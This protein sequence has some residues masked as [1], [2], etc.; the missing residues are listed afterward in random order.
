MYKSILRV[1]TLTIENISSTVL[2]KYDCMNHP[3]SK[4]RKYL[5]EH[6][7]EQSSPFPLG[8]YFILRTIF[9][10]CRVW[11]FINVFKVSEINSFKI[12]MMTAH[13]WNPQLKRL[14]ASGF[15][16]NIK[17]KAI[18]IVWERNLEY[19]NLTLNDNF[20]CG[21]N[22]ERIH[23]QNLCKVNYSM[24]AT[25]ASPLFPNPFASDRLET[26]KFRFT[27]IISEFGYDFNEKPMML[28]GI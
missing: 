4:N 13:H 8:P 22:G 16:Q 11:K 19:L 20:V 18:F 10:F 28:N 23:S 26:L 9:H 25:N 14:N 3:F 27:S 24:N 2:S 1:E 17:K 12:N 15:S 7:W 21:F 6:F 5:F